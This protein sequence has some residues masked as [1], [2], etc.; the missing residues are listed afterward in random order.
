MGQDSQDGN[1]STSTFWRYNDVYAVRDEQGNEVS[2]AFTNQPLLGGG[3]AHLVNAV[4]CR[5]E[6]A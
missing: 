3:V 5:D 6:R 4:S 2:F 1:V